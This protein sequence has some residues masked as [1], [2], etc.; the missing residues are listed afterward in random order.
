MCCTAKPPISNRFLFLF[1]HCAL[2]TEPL[3]QCTRN[4]TSLSQ[5]LRLCSCGS[6]TIT[7]NNE[8]AGKLS[9][10][11]MARSVAED[12]KEKYLALFGGVTHEKS[13]LVGHWNKLSRFFFFPKAKGQKQSE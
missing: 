2:T 10:V 7:E 12:T 1:E 9:E 11:L 8:V 13:E 4:L 5:S 6:K 3:Q